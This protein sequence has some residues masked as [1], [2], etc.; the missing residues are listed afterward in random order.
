MYK[1]LP[2]LN[3]Q[4]HDFL[5]PFPDL[6]SPCSESTLP[7][8]GLQRYS[9]PRLA[10]QAAEPFLMSSTPPT[11]SHLSPFLVRLG[12]RSLINRQQYPFFDEAV[13]LIQQ[14]LAT[15][16]CAIWELLPNR[17][18][19]LLVAG[20]GFPPHYI[21][22]RTIDASPR[23]LAGYTLHHNTAR[24]LEDYELVIT[25]DLALETRFRGAP[26]LHNLGIRGGVNGIVGNTQGMFGVLG[27]YSTQAGEFA[28]T[29]LD[30]LQVASTIL[31]T[32]ID[33]HQC[34]AR[35]QL[36]ERA[37]DATQNGIV[38]ADA[39]HSS[40]P[41]VYANQGLERVTG[42]SAQECLG[43]SLDFLAIEDNQQQEKE[44]LQECIAQAKEGQ[45]SLRSYRKD[46]TVFWNELHLSPVYDTQG[47]LTHFI[48]IQTDITP[49]KEAQELIQEKLTEVAKW[50]LRYEIAGRASGQILYE[51]DK[52]S[53]QI[54]W[55]VN[56]PSILGYEARE[57]PQD[58]QDW[59]NL[60]HPQDQIVFL[61]Q[62]KNSHIYQ[63]QF[64]GQYRVRHA[65]GHYLWIEDHTE[66]ILSEEGEFIGTLGMMTDISD[67]KQSE[68]QLKESEERL[69][70]IIQT[71]SDG[72]IIVDHKGVIQFVNPAAEEL[73]GRSQQ[74]L[75]YTYI[76]I[77]LVKEHMTEIVL[78]PPNGKITITQMR[79]T[80]IIWEEAPAFLLSLRNITEQSLAAQAQA[81]SEEKYRRIVE[82]TSE[83]IWILNE[84]QETIF[85]NSQLAKMLGY[86]VAE[87]LE[88]PIGSF[89][90]SKP[91]LALGDR[92]SYDLKLRRRDGQELWVMVSKS[93]FYDGFDQYTGELAMVSDIT[94]RKLMEQALYESE[95]RLEGILGSIQDVV[96]SAS[97]QTLDILY[98]NS[99]T[100]RVYGRPLQDFYEH[101][102]LWIELVH[103]EDQALIDCHLKRLL[104][105][106]QDE[107]E[108]RIVRPDGEVRWVLR[109]V[110]VVK[111]ECDYP[112]RL[113]G[114][115]SDITERKRA[116]QQ[117]HYNA[118]HDHLTDLP[119]RLLFLDRLEHAL[120]LGAR[121]HSHRFAVLFLDLD[122]FKI[123][124]DSLGHAYGDLLLQ[125]IARRLQK[126][127]RP[128]DT[129]ARLG[130]DEFTILIEDIYVEAEAIAVAERIQEQLTHP[131][132]LNGQEIFTGTSIGIALSHSHYRHPQEI[133]RDADT[134]MYQ[135]KARGKSCYS[136]FNQSM[137]QKAVVRLQRENDLR[138][139]L[140]RREFELF[141]QPIIHLK[142]G[143]LSG[144]EALI[145]WRHPEEGLIS[146]HQFIAIAEETG[147]ILPMGEWILGEACRQGMALQEQFP[148]SPPLKMSVNVSSRQMRDRRLLQDIDR[149]LEETQL[150]SGL[151][152][153]E[154]T[155]SIL[156]DNLELA[157]DVLLE[158]RHRGIEICLD[159][160]G[161]G[162]SSLSYLHRFPINTLKID[163]SFVM[164]MQPNDENSEIIRT[165]ITLAHTLG[166][167]VI[168]EGI[169][170]EMQLT[171]LRWLDCEQGQGYY[172]SHPIPRQELINYIQA[173]FDQ[174]KKLFSL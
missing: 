117:M 18:A 26:L 169:E 27:V 135:A 126:C 11:A 87:I 4:G 125:E 83:G 62:V 32:A 129:L 56:A 108:Y 61:E 131:F 144:L 149:F 22:H 160:F 2:A 71:I 93:P 23:S 167:D 65:Q 73:F 8:E 12:Q 132:D 9:V 137:H 38:I 92:T 29:T 36:L 138:R 122:G 171:Q 86:S 55:G 174:D 157:T 6:T 41:I 77:P 140:E 66:V 82:L 37:M 69:S 80:D 113:D 57:L 84:E 44:H 115:D 166:L 34:E 143:K 121:R 97:A 120:K 52:S 110:R 103:P 133:L 75:I 19:F 20:A 49:Q 42:Y 147:L 63:H 100:E 89:I 3:C 136:V 94:E 7:P 119:N 43:R 99:A 60:I 123:I 141:Y 105:R 74:E 14:A 90:I 76:G 58:F 10:D 68:N 81:E 155:E 98:L 40:H 21:G 51:W 111:D 172:F 130:G 170:T 159:D 64:Y 116:T 67:R 5:K 33:R 109:R 31:A 153:L 173:D 53:D 24:S 134:A 106:S 127:L 158:L 85:V 107:L 28:P 35:L 50:R 25:P 79:I 104:A 101:P 150:P 72:L 45:V 1:H 112:L 16:Y 13:L 96:W 146:P 152:K 124:N 128:A 114:I 156:M 46:A 59:L 145:R 118:T 151:L 161:T 17:S 148:Q 88:R 139:A 163:R 30:F 95:Q 48:G 15:E 164:S 70:R 142:T 102:R 154:I 78:T 91:S 165:I 54:L 162:Y 47:S 168:A 39:L